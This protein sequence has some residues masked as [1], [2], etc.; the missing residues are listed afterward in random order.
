M[1][2]PEDVQWQ[3][4]CLGCEA[5]SNTMT[6]ADA[7]PVKALKQSAKLLALQLEKKERV[8]SLVSAAPGVL[9]SIVISTSNLLLRL[10]SP[11]KLS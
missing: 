6:A 3:D 1:L 10:L 5:M 4:C 9:M 2:D 8:V 7:R 11:F